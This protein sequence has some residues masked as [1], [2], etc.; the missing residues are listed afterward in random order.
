MAIEGREIMAIRVRRIYGQDEPVKEPVMQLVDLI[1]L[2]CS[3]TDMTS[4][5]EYHILFQTAGSLEA[6]TIRAE[7]YLAQWV[8]EHPNFRVTRWHCAWPE[9]EEQKS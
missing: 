4:C 6:C 7:P 5:H 8:G 2:A 1:L 9:K 3:L